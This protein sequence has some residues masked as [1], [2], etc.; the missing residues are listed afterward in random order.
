MGQ[1]LRA[2]LPMPQQ[3]APWPRFTLKI[4]WLNTKHK[5]VFGLFVFLGTPC[6]GCII[7]Y[8]DIVFASLW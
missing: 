5:Q 2:A 8:E 1:A 6:L 7:W 4:G 3:T